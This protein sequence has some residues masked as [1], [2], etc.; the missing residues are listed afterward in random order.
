MELPV[1]EVVKAHTAS[2]L[3]NLVEREAQMVQA[4]KLENERINA[5]VSHP[6]TFAW[7]VAALYL[8]LLSLFLWIYMWQEIDMSPQK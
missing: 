3:N 8:R 4:D 1:T 6:S 7:Q 2:Q 5:K